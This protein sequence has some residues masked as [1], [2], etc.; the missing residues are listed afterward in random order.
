MTDR[1][2]LPKPSPG[3]DRRVGE[4]DDHKSIVDLN[5]TDV[6]SEKMDTPPRRTALIPD[7]QTHD[8]PKPDLMDSDSRLS[9]PHG[10]HVAKKQEQD[11]ID[12]I[13]H[14]AHSD[15]K[16]S[17]GPYVNPDR[18]RNIT[19][20]DDAGHGN[21]R[22]RDFNPKMYVLLTFTSYILLA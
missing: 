14:P 10:S 7:L 20:G 22:V 18:Q 1:A 3:P 21:G 6:S 9:S 15:S 4:L 16:P 8:V 12:M 11:D 2:I 19:A 13:S 17:N 5:L